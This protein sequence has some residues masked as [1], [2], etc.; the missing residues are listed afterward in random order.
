MAIRDGYPYVSVNNRV[1]FLEVPFVGTC[2]DGHAG[3]VRLRRINPGA[4]RSVVG[5]RQGCPPSLRSP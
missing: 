2:R 4:D 5:H 3:H 1:S